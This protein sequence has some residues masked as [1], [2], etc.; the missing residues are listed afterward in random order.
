M[1]CNTGPQL[2]IQPWTLRLCGMCCNPEA[3]EVPQMYFLSYKTFAKDVFV[4]ILKPALKRPCLTAFIFPAF[5]GALLWP[6]CQWN[7]VKPLP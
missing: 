7:N 3:T 5:V 4:N 6:A 2:G 1:T